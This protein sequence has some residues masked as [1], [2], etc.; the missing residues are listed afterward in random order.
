MAEPQAN[1]Q[2]DVKEDATKVPEA[3]EAIEGEAEEAVEI[4]PIS[5][6][7]ELYRKMIHL[8]SL[9]IPIGYALLGKWNMV[10]ILL[11]LTTIIVF[12]D[13]SRHRSA[14]LQQ[15]VDGLFGKMLRAHEMDGEEK[16]LS[17]ASYMLLAACGCILFLPKI[18]AITAFSV[19]IISDTAAALVG[20][21]W[22]EHKLLDKSVEGTLAFVASG[23][24]VV[25]VVGLLSGGDSHISLEFYMFGAI[26][27]I[28]GAMVELASNRWHI[29]DNISI[30]LAV[31]GA[32]LVLG[33]LLPDSYIA[34]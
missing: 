1:T 23:I 20:R 6:S 19:L 22:G 31:G 14:R 17:G 9:V 29:D 16:H 5:Y 25:I 26:A 32:M 10:F 30:P 18:I 4:V 3:A 13:H 15:I 12:I 24:M 28:L 33:M 2:K 11:P 27:V 7:Q 21:K 34:F 8:F